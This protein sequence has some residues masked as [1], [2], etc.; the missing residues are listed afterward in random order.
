MIFSFDSDVF[1]KKMY[2]YVV[3]IEKNTL[4][5][6]TYTRS[7][8]VRFWLFFITVWLQR[9]LTDVQLEFDVTAVAKLNHPELSMMF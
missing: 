7:K 4:Y 9:T 6:P 5:E 1:F 8:N 2:N 3:K